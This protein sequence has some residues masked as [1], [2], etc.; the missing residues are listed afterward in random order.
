MLVVVLVTVLVAASAL[1]SLL[2]NELPSRGVDDTDG[3]GRSRNLDLDRRLR[4]G[5]GRLGLVG[6]GK[7]GSNFELA[8]TE[9][10]EDGGLADIGETEQG[11]SGSLLLALGNLAE[12]S[13][14]LFPS[15]TGDSG[16]EIG[17]EGKGGNPSLESLTGNKVCLLARP[18]R[19]RVLERTDLVD[20]D[21]HLS[22]GLRHQV[23]D[24]LTPGARDVTSVNYLE[25]NVSSIERSLERRQVGVEEGRDVRVVRVLVR[26]VR[27]AGHGHTRQDRRRSKGLD[28]RRVLLLLLIAVLLA[29]EG[30]PGFGNLRLVECRTL[31]CLQDA[32]PPRAQREPGP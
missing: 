2:L 13:E 1:A 15:G 19:Q 18:D 31:L 7:S 3:T 5:S 26:Q 17:G 32:S 8:V 10:V 20:N 29:L 24:S 25:K 9:S 30:C 23:L 4:G 6:G 12:S 11:D 14:E 28:S 21:E 27:N 16:E 22:V